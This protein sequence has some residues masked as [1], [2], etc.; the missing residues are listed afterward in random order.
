M[1]WKST[2]NG[3]EKMKGFK[4]LAAG[5]YKKVWTR[6]IGDELGLWVTAK[7]SGWTW[8]AS[9]P[10]HGFA[11][12]EVETLWPPKEYGSLQQALE[13]CEEMLAG[14][15][16]AMETSLTATA[17]DMRSGPRPWRLLDERR[18]ECHGAGWQGVLERR[19]S[20]EWYA[21]VHLRMMYW[22]VVRGVEIDCA[23]EEDVEVAQKALEE[24][25]TDK[26]K[27]LLHEFAHWRGAMEQAP[28]VE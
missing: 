22:G 27:L 13:R 21:E 9:I 14:E 26:L 15:I 25:L 12:V 1:W 11:S 24:E 7:A 18:W 19:E 16:S 20:G 23:A 8:G 2:F 5:R 4:K 6:E 10:I 17:A 3:R 28:S